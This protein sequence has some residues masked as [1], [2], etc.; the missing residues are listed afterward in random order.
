MRGFEELFS[1]G[2]KELL[3]CLHGK[4]ESVGLRRQRDEV[5]FQVEGADILFCVDDNGPG[6]DVPGGL[7]G[8]FQGIH[9]Q[10]FSEALPF[11]ILVNTHTT[12]KSDTDRT[13]GRQ[14]PGKLRGKVRPE[15]G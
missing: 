1:G 12:E 10:D 8:P 3:N 13:A 7:P 2:E 9:E 4:E 14:L 5:V 11:A 15:D 6:R